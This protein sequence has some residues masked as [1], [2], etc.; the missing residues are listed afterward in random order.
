MMKL[1]PQKW[2]IRYWT[3][4]NLSSAPRKE[5]FT[6]T[7]MARSRLTEVMSQGFPTCIGLFPIKPDGDSPDICET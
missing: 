4:G 1:K 3:D 2:E 7:E 6:S 5:T